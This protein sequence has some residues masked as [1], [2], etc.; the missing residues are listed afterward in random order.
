M[1]VIIGPI[2]EPIMIV[3]AWGGFRNGKQ[4]PSWSSLELFFDI[5]VKHFITKQVDVMG[6]LSWKAIFEIDSQSSDS[7]S[8]MWMQATLFT[9]RYATIFFRG[10]I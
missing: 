3:L 1:S 7:L 6:F 5:N 8:R 4:S 9:S 2:V 10:K